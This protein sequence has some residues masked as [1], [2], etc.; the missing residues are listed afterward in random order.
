MAR[1]IFL[2]LL[3]IGCNYT[4]I[5]AQNCNYEIESFS[6]DEQSLISNFN[7]DS[8]C[9]YEGSL[10][11]AMLKFYHNRDI[12]SAEK[13]VEI[14][15]SGKSEAQRYYLT[16]NAIWNEGSELLEEMENSV[17]LDAISLKTFVGAAE[18]TGNY[19]PVFQFY[20]ASSEYSW[21]GEFINLFKKLILVDPNIFM[22]SLSKTNEF[23]RKDIVCRIEEFTSPNE[24]LELKGKMS[25]KNR[26][27]FEVSSCF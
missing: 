27:L 17:D 12:E 10:I 18:I 2:F 5:L 20:Y 8:E 7:N 22:D 4:P 24:T 9:S 6:K 1:S 25:E 15:P 3:F 19:S 14:T 23:L 21:S 16:E 13:L 11:A 26:Q